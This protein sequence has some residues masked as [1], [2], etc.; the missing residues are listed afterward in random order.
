MAKWE[1]KTTTLSFERLVCGVPQGSLTEPVL[2][3]L[4]NI[5]F[6]GYFHSV[7][8]IFKVIFPAVSN[9]KTLKSRFVPYGAN[10]NVGLLSLQTRLVRHS[11]NNK[12]IQV[13]I[14]HRPPFLSC[15]MVIKWEKYCTEHRDKRLLTNTE[16]MVF[17]TH[18]WTKQSFKLMNILYWNILSYCWK[19]FP[20]IWI[21]Y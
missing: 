5:I 14:F 15:R 19:S 12:I 8:K 18:P 17:I 10:R 11:K 6:P 4:I 2:F 9:G 7:G 3:L 21:M 16:R 1:K 20:S 13:K